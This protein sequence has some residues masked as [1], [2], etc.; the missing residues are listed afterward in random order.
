MKVK[1]RNG[2]RFALKAKS[3]SNDDPGGMKNTSFLSLCLLYLGL[4]S[5]DS[6]L[7]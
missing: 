5:E 7:T 6:E 4:Y 3:V 2:H 1:S